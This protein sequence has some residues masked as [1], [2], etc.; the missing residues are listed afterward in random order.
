M[1]GL[2]AVPFWF[3]YILDCGSPFLSE[4]VRVLFS[5]L[6]IAMLCGTD[7]ALMYINKVYSAMALGL[8]FFL[9]ILPA[10]VLGKI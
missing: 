1:L 6:A 3:S 4:A 9:I 8:L 2:R 7:Q 5:R 10:V